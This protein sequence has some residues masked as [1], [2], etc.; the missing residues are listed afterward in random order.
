[1]YVDVLYQHAWSRDDGR[2][3]TDLFGCRNPNL[4]RSEAIVR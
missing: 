1:M 3:K 2:G 4:E